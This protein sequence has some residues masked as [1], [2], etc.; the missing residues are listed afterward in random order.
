[1]AKLEGIKVANE[2]TVEYNGFVYELV[3]DGAE[4][5]DLIQCLEE[6][7]GDLTYGAFYQVIGTDEY[8][9]MQFL[10]DDNDERDRSVT[11]EEYKV[12]RKSRAVTND[13]LT[14]AEG[15]VTITLP[16]GTKLEG[17]PSDL[18]KITRS[19]Q[20]LQNEQQGQAEQVTSVE[21]PVEEIEV[22][23]ESE[24][25]AERLQVGDCAKVIG[26]GWF[27]KG[28][29]VKILK[30][31]GGTHMPFYVADLSDLEHVLWVN[32]ADLERVEREKECLQV[33]DY[34]K[35]ITQDDNGRSEYGD[36]VKVTEDDNGCV[37]FNTN[38][39]DGSYAGWHYEG[40][41]VKATDEEV[42]EA[43]QALLKKGDYAR[44]IGNTSSHKFEIGTIVK[45]ERY[46]SGDDTFAAYYLDGSDFWYAY[47]RDF[48]PL[49]KEE[50]EHITREAEEEKKATVER[51]KWAA[52]G[53]EVGEIKDGDVVKVIDN[54]NGS[55]LNKG[56]IGEVSQSGGRTFRVN[57]PDCTDVNWFVPGR[58]ELIV[59]VEQRFDTV[60]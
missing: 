43:K 53:R 36:I 38:H 9:D 40:E 27:D 18:E 6:D 37:P 39:L 31:D 12:F 47:R 33:G 57:T 2:N 14:D 21:M 48:E 56:D 46:A 29:I 41:L 16:D 35:V 51:A 34:A 58:V 28:T 19:M 4:T 60:G 13:K 54:T 49:T 26:S 5:D 42:L 55:H 7:S 30:Y 59:P 22:E 50:T 15:V 52:I 44:I 45:L 11:D 1:M 8:N 24:S 17:T 3:T 32:E 25:V 20:A 10:D 23:D